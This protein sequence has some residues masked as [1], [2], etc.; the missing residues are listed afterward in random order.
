M[1][2]IFPFVVRPGAQP[3]TPA[4][5]ESATIII[6]PGVRYE[7]PDGNDKAAPPSVATGGRRGRKTKAR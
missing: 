6:F 5:G 3:R 7:H 1:A 2:T 4:P